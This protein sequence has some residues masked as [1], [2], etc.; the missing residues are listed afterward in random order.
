MLL[1]CSVALTACGPAQSPP[2]APPP[3]A[4]STQTVASPTSPSP[5]LG[6]LVGR[7]L[8]PDGGYILHLRKL[9]AATGRLDA[10]YFNPQPIHVSQA[11]A[12]VEG[13]KMTVFV[14]LQ[15]ENYP[16]CTY[17]LTYFPATDQLYGTYYQAALQQSYDVEFERER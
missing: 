2:S 10:G 1:A 9:D 7:W 4:A 3:P 15:D 12:K 17:R 16:G 5:D 11:E 14:E 13:G 6:K 8:R